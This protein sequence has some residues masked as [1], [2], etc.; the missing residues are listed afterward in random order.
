MSKL[1][2]IITFLIFTAFFTVFS[3]AETYSRHDITKLVRK[4]VEDNLPIPDK[5]KL[6][7]TPSTIDSRIVLKPC[8]IPLR[9]NIPENYSSRNVNVKV[10]CESSTPW[11]IFIPVKVSIQVPIIVSKTKITKGSM[12]TG[13]NIAISWVDLHKIRGEYYESMNLILGARAKRSLSEGSIINK[14][15]ICVICKGENITIIAKSNDFLV[16]TEG[17]A[18]KNGTYGEQVMVKNIRSGRTISAQV[19]TV[20]EVIIN[21]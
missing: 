7:A 15:S 16:K 3:H 20:N 13:E 12:I 19:S 21:L 9:A 18:L 2:I 1:K 17:I 14:R 6:I 8:P 5:G 11:S 10:S 4:H